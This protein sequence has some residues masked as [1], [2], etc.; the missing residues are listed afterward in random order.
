MHAEPERHSLLERHPNKIALP[1][2]LAACFIL[3]IAGL[4]LPLMDAHTGILWK[5]WKKSYSAWAGVVALWQQ[6]ELL[7]GAVLF[8]FSIVFPILKLI[9]VSVVWFVRLA[10]EERSKVLHWLEVLG[11]WSMLDVF[12]VSILIV[13]V[14]LGPMAN[15]E[16]RLGIYFFTAAILASMLTTKRIDRLAHRYFRRT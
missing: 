15:I 11:K 9:A 5:H 4:S 13:L 7:L 2:A 14:K 6:N 1:I 12:I 10:D 16:P 3:L 8:F